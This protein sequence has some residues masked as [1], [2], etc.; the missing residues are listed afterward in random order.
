MMRRLWILSTILICELSCS[1]KT[2]NP[3]S[4]NQNPADSTISTNNKD[5]KM[6]NYFPFKIFDNDGQFTITASTESPELYPKYAD[7]FEKHGYSGNGYCWEG[8][9]VQIL[10]KINPELLEHIDFDPEAGAFFA[11]AASKEY[12][13]KFVELLNPIFSDLTKL[14]EYVKKADRSRI[15]D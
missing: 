11:N 15:D 14:E 12:Q 4:G 5:H 13:I 1:Q 6:T 9:I 10:E 8:H 7:F 3:N 2:D